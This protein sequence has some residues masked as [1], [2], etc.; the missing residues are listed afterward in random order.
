[1]R[2]HRVRQIYD[3]RLRSP[4]VVR[5]DARVANHTLS[6]DDVACGQRQ[7]PAVVAVRGLEIDPE[8]LV[9]FTHVV[10]KLVAQPVLPATR[11][12]WS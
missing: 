7:R 2:A 9:R 1:M 5:V 4:C 8:R 12:P 3:H 10:W 11:F 6:V